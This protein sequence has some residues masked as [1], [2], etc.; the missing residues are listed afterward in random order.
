MQALP[1]G[2]QAAAIHLEKLKLPADATVDPFNGAPLLVRKLPAGW[3]VY[4]VGRN[5]N[6]DGGSFTYDLDVGLGP[7][8]GKDRAAVKADR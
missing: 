4:S 7:P 5:R 1:P 8:G 2:E 3:V 6:D